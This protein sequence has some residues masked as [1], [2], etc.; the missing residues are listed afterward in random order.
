[1]PA[2]T[3]VFLQATAENNST[4]STFTVCNILKSRKSARGGLSDLDQFKVKRR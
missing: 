1:M 2:R 3:F 4:E